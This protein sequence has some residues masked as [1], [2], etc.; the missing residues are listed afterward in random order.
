MID[1][2]IIVT[3]CESDYLFA[4]GCCASIRYFLGDIPIC[5][6]IDGNFSASDAQNTY[7]VRIL[8]RSQITNPFLRKHSFGWGI[9]KMVAFW[10]SPWKH[11]LMLDADTIVWGNILKY[12]N[13]H[14]ADIIIDRPNKCY[15]DASIS[16]YFFEISKIEQHF[17]DFNW[18]AHRSDYY[19][20][21]AFFGKRDIFSI[22]EYRNI[23]EFIEE[24][25]EVFKYGEMGF[26]NFMIF[27]AADEGRIR[28]GQEEMQF[29]VPNFEQEHVRKRFTIEKD[30]GPIL[31]GEEATI[32]HWCGV[33]K[34]TV[35]NSKIYSE[36]MS[37]FRRKFLRDS[38]GVTGGKA[39]VLLQIEDWQRLIRVYQRKI[40]RRLAIVDRIREN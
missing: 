12:A 17:P 20:T 27:R 19:C 34:P 14:E 1:F 28:L 2:G 35:S 31:S 16:K 26:L 15:T 40:R 9:T 30:R 13:F 25:P 21:G 6:L 10:E 11:F 37:F 5:L 38:A 7:G 8:N 3:C 22:S 36:P 24:N 39:E 18:Q 33:E 29:L 23:L 4:K 32:V